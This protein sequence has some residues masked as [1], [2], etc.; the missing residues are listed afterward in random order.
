[1]STGIVF[2]KDTVYQ[3]SIVNIV[4]PAGMTALDLHAARI[5][6]RGKRDA[7][8]QSK[9]HRQLADHDRQAGLMQAQGHAAGEVASAADQDE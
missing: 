9:R 3:R 5:D 2:C 8:A 7:S 6:G 4:N 1:M